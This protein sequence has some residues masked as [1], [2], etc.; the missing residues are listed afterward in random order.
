MERQMGRA[1]I[2]FSWVLWG[3]KA[4]HHRPRTVGNPMNPSNLVP[5]LLTCTCTTKQREALLTPSLVRGI[6]SVV[7]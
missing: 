7:R 2:A 3:A 5:S 6:G 4:A 1:V